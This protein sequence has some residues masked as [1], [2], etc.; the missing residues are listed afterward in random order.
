M[1]DQQKNQP[2]KDDLKQGKPS[3]ATGRTQPPEQNLQPAHPPGTVG[4]IIPRNEYPDVLG[5]EADEIHDGEMGGST[6]AV[7]ITNPNKKNRAA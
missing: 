6:R 3:P 1:S 2:R 4:H 7:R 5:G